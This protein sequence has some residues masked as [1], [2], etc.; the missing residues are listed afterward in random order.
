[1][2]KKKFPFVST[3]LKKMLRALGNLTF[4]CSGAV[5]VAMS[6]DAWNK[7]YR[8]SKALIPDA[9]VDRGGLLYQM[10]ANC[11][12]RLMAITGHIFLNVMNTTSIARLDVFTVVIP[13]ICVQKN[14]QP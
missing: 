1:L 9:Y 13:W 8:G 2:G 10:A 5:F 14:W 12:L 3:E 11:S 4:G 6:A 7:R